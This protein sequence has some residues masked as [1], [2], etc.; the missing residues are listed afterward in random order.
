MSNYN[1]YIDFKIKQN[2]KRGNDLPDLNQRLQVKKY[3]TRNDRVNI[4]LLN[5]SH[6]LDAFG[7]RHQKLNSS[8]SDLKPSLDT[9]VR[10]NHQLNLK[11]DLNQ[12][13]FIKNIKILRSLNT[14]DIEGASVHTKVIAYPKNIMGVEDIPGAKPSRFKHRW[15]D[16]KQV[17]TN[18]KYDHMFDEF[19][20]RKHDYSLNIDSKVDPLAGSRERRKDHLKRV[21]HEEADFKPVNLY[22]FRLSRRFFKGVSKNKSNVELKWREKINQKSQSTRDDKIDIKPSDFCKFYIN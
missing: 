14:N 19:G 9:M 15:F 17:A 12:S 8:S 13:S 7:T 20:N 2:R 10:P 11:M 6:S 18:A 22:N 16:K 21:D 4:P 1:Q 3:N 5:D